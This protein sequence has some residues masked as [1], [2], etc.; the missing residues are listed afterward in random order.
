MADG[1]YQKISATHARAL[2]VPERELPG[3][4]RVLV[5]ARLYLYGAFYKFRFREVVDKKRPVMLAVTAPC[6]P[7]NHVRAIRRSERQYRNEL[8]G[9]SLAR[10]LHQHVIRLDHFSL[11]LTLIVQGNLS[12]YAPNIFALKK[13]FGVLRVV[14][15]EDIAL[16]LNQ[17]FGVTHV[18]AQVCGHLA[19]VVEECWETIFIGINQRVLRVE[20]VERGR[21]VVSVNNS[22]ATVA[23]VVDRLIASLVVARVR[24]SRRFREGVNDPVK[25]P[26]VRASD[27]SITVIINKRIDCM[28]TFVYVA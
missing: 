12:R 15:A 22:L 21:P 7:A 3:E 14:E 25:C 11:M 23:Y 24:I 1:N 5:Y 18:S 26:I 17:S 10:Q 27:V 6:E 16:R 2:L 28:D 4:L 8:V 20:D 9:Y 13:Y 19:R